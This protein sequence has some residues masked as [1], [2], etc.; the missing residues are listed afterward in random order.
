[1]FNSN[2]IKDQGLPS[3]VGRSHRIYD[4]LLEERQKLIKKFGPTPK[5]VA[6]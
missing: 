3:R 1:M 5:D 4:R 6:V 2:T